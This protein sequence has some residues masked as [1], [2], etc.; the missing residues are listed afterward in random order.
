M[1][2]E[3]NQYAILTKIF[4]EIF[5][6]TNSAFRPSVAFKIYDKSITMSLEKF[7][8]ILGVPMCSAL[9]FAKGRTPM[10]MCH[11]LDQ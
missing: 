3:S 9:P 2:D 4:V 10:I 5:K 7:C 1:A 8:G 11:S 6:F